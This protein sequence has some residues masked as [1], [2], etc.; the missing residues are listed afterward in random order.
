MTSDTKP[1]R[2]WC[3]WCCGTAP[4]NT[5][6]INGGGIDKGGSGG[7]DIYN[8][9]SG[10]NTDINNLNNPQAQ[11]CI[12]CGMKMHRC[13]SPGSACNVLCFFRFA[14]ILILGSCFIWSILEWEAVKFYFRLAL[15]WVDNM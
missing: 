14:F 13:C 8:S 11:M 4:N 10:S 5:G 12:C 1:R 2:R 15:Q 3:A 6:T 9:R 7:G